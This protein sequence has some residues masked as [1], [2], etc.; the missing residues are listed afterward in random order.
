MIPL[1]GPLIGL[2]GSRLVGPPTPNMAGE[3]FAF[4]LHRKPGAFFFVG[5]NPD[6]AFA[7]DPAMPVEEDELVH[8]THVK[9]K[10]RKNCMRACAC[11]C[12]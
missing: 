3:D 9:L 4:F 5:S 11:A 8:G 1:L 6:A 7:M 10:K 2:L 12:S